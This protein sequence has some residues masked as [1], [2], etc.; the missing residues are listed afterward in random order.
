MLADAAR[1]RQAGDDRQADRRGDPENRS[2]EI[3]GRAYEDFRTLFANAESK[4]GGQFNTPRCMVRVLGERL[5]PG[6]E[7]STIPDSGRRE[8]R[9]PCPHKSR[10]RRRAYQTNPQK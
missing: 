6:K 9:L 1:Q 2:K 3:L 10:L 5:A 8:I 7:E 4:G